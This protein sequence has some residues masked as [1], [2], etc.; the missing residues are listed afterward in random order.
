MASDEGC[1]G[2]ACDS[3]EWD[4]RDATARISREQFEHLNHAA[5]HL[6]AAGLTKE[7]E[8][9]QQ[10]AA[11][12]REELMELLTDNLAQMTAAM[13]EL[14]EEIAALEGEDA[15]DVAKSD[16]ACE[17]SQPQ[18][19]G[20]VAMAQPDAAPAKQV[21][22][23]VRVVELNLTDL[24]NLGFDVAFFSKTEQPAGVVEILNALQRENL[25]KVLSWPTVVTADGGSFEV[26]HQESGAHLDVRAKLLD[27]K[28][29]RVDIHP[30]DHQP[31]ASAEQV[32]NAQRHEIDTRVEM[33]LGKTAVLSGHVQ[34][35]VKSE[36]LVG[37][38]SAEVRETRQQVQTFFLVTPEL[39]ESDR[40]V[41]AASHSEPNVKEHREGK[42]RVK[43]LHIF[44]AGPGE[45]VPNVRFAR[46]TIER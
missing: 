33:E 7:A 3:P 13:A 9:V 29:V 23:N 32:R 43:S 5:E 18:R 16:V 19:R 27:G 46:P 4:S 34:E 12:V 21:A 15:S 24:R 2:G 41:S 36:K 1:S 40:A 44:E 8:C 26:K 10:M 38:K 30:R 14:E 42:L 31:G 28:H 39:V 11:E 6:A 17:T 20:H 37:L 45:M 35:R 25:A 22:V